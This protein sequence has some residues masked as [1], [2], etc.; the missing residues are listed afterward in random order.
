MNEALLG[1]EPD[2]LIEQ[3][4]HKEKMV[5]EF[6]VR[7]TKVKAELTL[8]LKAKDNAERMFVADRNT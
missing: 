6:D 1:R 4:R 8:T 5:D 3:L 7:A 2:N